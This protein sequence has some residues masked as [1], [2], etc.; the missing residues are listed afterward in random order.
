MGKTRL[1]IEGE[2]LLTYSVLCWIQVESKAGKE[3]SWISSRTVND[4]E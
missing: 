1:K 3:L 4:D 2:I